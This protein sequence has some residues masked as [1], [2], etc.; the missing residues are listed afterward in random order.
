MISKKSVDLTRDQKR[1]ALEYLMFLKRKR[2]GKGKGR[3]CVDG[4]KQRAY[5]TCSSPR[6]AVRSHYLVCSEIYFE[7]VV[8]GPIRIKEL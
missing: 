1:E 7:I 3:G 5:M 6:R 2:S 8:I 4:R